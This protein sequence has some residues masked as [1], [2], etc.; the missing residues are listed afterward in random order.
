MRTA[1]IALGSLAILAITFAGTV[2]AGCF[3]QPTLAGTTP[4]GLEWAAVSTGTALPIRTSETNPSNGLPGAVVYVNINTGQVQFDPKGLSVVTFILTYTTGTVNISAATPGPFQ[5][6]TGTG[7]FSYSD[8]SGSERTF[9]CKDPSASGLSPTTYESRVGLTVGGPS[10]ALNIGGCP[11]CAS[12]NGS[13]NL[14]WAFPSDLIKSGSLPLV[15]ATFNAPGSNY[16]R[17]IG[18]NSN[19]N[20]NILGF[21]LGQSVFQ[22]TVNGITGNQVGAVIPVVPEPSTCAMALAGLAW[23]GCSVFRRR[24]AC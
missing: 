10:S 14:P 15:A 2:S 17:T 3:V 1:V 11:T 16:F 7:D 19:L 8:V 23:G 5:Y 9:P 12:T 13:W 22:Y 20:A 18:Q 6:T 21:G 4:S 24:R